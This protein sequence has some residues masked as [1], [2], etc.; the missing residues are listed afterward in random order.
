MIDTTQVLDRLL[1]DL[2]TDS[3]ANLTFWTQ[4]QLIRYLDEG[5]KRLS[6]KAMLFVERDTSQATV[7]G[8]P[9]YTLPDRHNDTLHVS[10]GAAPLR[11]STTIELESRDPAFQT[12][13]GTPDHWYEDNGPVSAIGLSPVPA[14][15]A[16]LAMICSVHPPDLDVDRVNTL[17]QAP[18]PVSIYLEYFVLAK[19]YGAESESEEPDLA[20]HCAA[21][22]AM[23]EQI[24]AHLYGGA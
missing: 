14:A 10:C 4:A 19:A 7:P 17:L 12:T 3:Y 21:Q 24:F 8:T 22:V 20:Q 9:T 11:P 1:P 23:L 2:H 16:T 13:P 15:A 6:N 18:A 5:A